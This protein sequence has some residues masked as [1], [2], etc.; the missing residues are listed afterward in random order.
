MKT[1]FYLFLAAALC[2][3]SGC[4]EIKTFFSW[5]DADD[6]ERCEIITVTVYLPAVAADLGY[7]D[8]ASSR[9]QAIIL[10]GFQHVLTIDKPT[11]SSYQPMTVPVGFK[12]GRGIVIRF[13]FDRTVITSSEMDKLSRLANSSTKGS[14]IVVEGHTDSKGSSAYN[15][16]LSER[17]A[18]A[19]KTALV[20]MGM[21]AD[22]I[23]LLERGKTSPLYSNDT[24]RHRALNRR[25]T[26]EAE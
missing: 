14:R 19:V 12:S 24:E 22:S 21:P 9:E 15:L 26:V 5:N 23:R 7:S 11:E 16:R 20:R 17:R 8:I 1:L 2:F 6:Q 13:E 4:S 10:G 25:A 18:S 3:S